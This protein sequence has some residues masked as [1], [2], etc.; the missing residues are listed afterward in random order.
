MFTITHSRKRIHKFH[1]I[2]KSTVNLNCVTA[3]TKKIANALETV[4]LSCPID[5]QFSLF[6]MRLWCC[7]SEEREREKPPRNRYRSNYTLIWL[8]GGGF[9]LHLSNPPYFLWHFIKSV[10]VQCTNFSFQAY[11][12]IQSGKKSQS[13][14]IF[15]VWDSVVYI[16]QVWVLVLCE[17]TNDTIELITCEF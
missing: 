6:H 9:H 13:E 10:C 3:S 11:A 14:S 12:P 1:K 17:C 5:H 2:I 15:A 4:F 7:A 8:I 16:Q